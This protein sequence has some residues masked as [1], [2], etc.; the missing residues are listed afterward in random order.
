MKNKSIHNNELIKKIIY[1]I[2][3]N[4]ILIIVTFCA[5]KVN[6]GYELYPRKIPVGCLV[7]SVVYLLIFAYI[8]IFFKKADYRKI[9]FLYFTYFLITAFLSISNIIMLIFVD[10][11]ADVYKL[12]GSLSGIFTST[13]GGFNYFLSK[14]FDVSYYIICTIISIGMILLISLPKIKIKNN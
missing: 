11:N 7:I 9:F 1:Y 2:T 3:A 13:M 12:I 4:I 5:I 10:K 8:I 6:L 14:N